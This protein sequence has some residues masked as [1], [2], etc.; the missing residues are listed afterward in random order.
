MN[1]VC[2]NCNRELDTSFFYTDRRWKGAWGLGF[3][4][5]CKECTK[6]RSRSRYAKNPRAILD[7]NKDYKKRYPEKRKT[8]D[9]RRTYSL[10]LENWNKMFD[11][12]NGVC[13]ICE[14]ACTTRKRL[15]VDHDHETGQIRGLLCNRCNISLGGF[16]D[17][18]TLLQKAV[19][20]LQQFSSPIGVEIEK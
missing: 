2:P 15:A 11:E 14:R 6:E 12:Q 9:L 18:L 16:K 8:W 1:K 19:K 5:P 3:L 20:Y 13:A 4:T 17:S 7:K 10:T